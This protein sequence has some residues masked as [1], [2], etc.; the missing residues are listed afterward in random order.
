MHTRILLISMIVHG[1]ARFHFSLFIYIYI[2][3]TICFSSSVYY[4]FSLVPRF[5]YIS[6][7]FSVSLSVRVC[8]AYCAR[9][10]NIEFAIK[11]VRPLAIDW[12]NDHAQAHIH[13]NTEYKHWLNIAIARKDKCVCHENHRINLTL[14]F[15]SS[16][17]CSCSSSTWE[18]EKWAH[19]LTA[20]ASFIQYTNAA[21]FMRVHKH[22]HAPS[23]PI[24]FLE[25]YRHST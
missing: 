25:F 5:S 18:N 21:R 8:G 1:I 11:S 23:M 22:A 14:Q 9:F 6:T 7:A 24:W 12:Y 13:I 20:V 4:I 2:C 19:C 16:L 10:F 3:Y 15:D 17:I